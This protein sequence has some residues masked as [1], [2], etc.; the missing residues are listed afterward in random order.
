MDLSEIVAVLESLAPVRLAADWDNVGLL[1]EGDRGVRRI[2][3]TV[4]LTEAVLDEALA[5]GADLVVSYHPPIFRGLKRLVAR[6]PLQR[7]LLRAARSGLHVY[8]P[9]TAL[10]AVPGGMT[11][12]LLEPFGPLADA[13]P[14]APDPLRPD[15]GAGRVARLSGPAPLDLLLPRIKAHLGLAAVRLATLDP[16][17]VVERVAVCPGAGGSV[18]EQVGDVDLLLTGEMRHHDVLE[19]VARGASVVL[20]DHTNTE[21]GYLPRLAQRLAE[22]TGLPVDVSSIDRDPLAVV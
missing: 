17:R 10:D 6:D 19:R 18:F 21:R 11:D 7:T 14:I 22:R 20:T 1:L 8:S 16:S 12:W 2:L 15:A 9:H 13:R 3:C 5:R 4:D